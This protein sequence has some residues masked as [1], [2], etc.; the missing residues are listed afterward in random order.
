MW[1]SNVARFLIEIPTLELDPLKIV[2]KYSPRTWSVENLKFSYSP[3]SYPKLIIA[4]VSNW[5]LN[6][7]IQNKSK[8]ELKFNYLLDQ[9]SLWYHSVSISPPLV[10]MTLT[11]KYP[12]MS[13]RYFSIVNYIVDLKLLKWF[14]KFFYVPFGGRHQLD[15]LW[16]QTRQNFTFQVFQYQFRQVGGYWWSHGVIPI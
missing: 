9:V 11:S 5:K 4:T 13:L 1:F 6:F 8:Y 7:K 3:G 2:L 10:F 15:I 14:Q 16:A 12:K